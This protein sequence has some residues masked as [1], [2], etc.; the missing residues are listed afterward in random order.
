M[1][2]PHL[3]TYVV[4]SMCG[5]VSHKGT[6]FCS[7]YLRCLKSLA[8]AKGFSIGF[9]FLDVV[10]AFASALRELVFSTPV[11]DAAIAR[12]ITHLEC[13]QSIFVDFLRNIQDSNAFQK[14]KVPSDLSLLVQ[15]VSS[16]TFF[17]MKGSEKIVNYIKGTGAGNPLADILFNFLMARVQRFVHTKLEEE[18]LNIRLPVPPRNPFSVDLGSCHSFSST[19]YFDDALYARMEAS[20]FC[21]LTKSCKIAAIV[22][23]GFVQH[24]FK[25]NL[26]K[27]KSEFMF[28]FRG[29]GATEVHNSVYGKP[30]PSVKVITRAYGEIVLSAVH[31]YLHMGSMASSD[32]A[33]LPDTRHRSHSANV[34]YKDTVSI[35]RNRNSSTQSAESL[36]KSLCIS[37]LTYN[38]GSV[39]DWTKGATRLF[40]STYYK[41]FRRVFLSRPASGDVVHVSN[42]QLCAKF[43]L[44]PPDFVRRKLRLRYLRRLIVYGPPSLW[45][46]ILSEYE[47]TEKSWLHTLLQDLHFVWVRVYAFRHLPDPNDSLEPW[48]SLLVDLPGQFLKALDTLAETESQSTSYHIQHSSVEVEALF[49]CDICFKKFPNKAELGAHRHCAHGVKVPLRRKICTT[50]CLFCMKEFHT[51]TKLVQHVAYSSPKCKP[52]YINSINEIPDDLY[53]ELE[54]QASKELKLLRAQG[55]SRLY[56]PA[57]TYR[58]PGPLPCAP[59]HPVALE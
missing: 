40:D 7:H 53:N 37:R 25:V 36:T 46:L 45:L 32:N 9:L 6:D 17:V 11:S 34:A 54:L 14:A 48:L 27:G 3:E 39:H 50:H 22:I 44:P 21:C 20:P 33:S 41:L 23:D 31:S 42:Q 12:F 28:K 5:G 52:Y 35:C 47:A 38:L 4:D 49:Q 43:I 26:K 24:G 10:T 8:K 30:V 19:S 29:H 58:R 13:E 59:M 55:K 2:L 57:K 15:S 51:R 56:H 18:E 1:L 16:S